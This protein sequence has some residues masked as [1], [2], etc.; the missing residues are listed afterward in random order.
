MDKDDKDKKENDQL[1]NEWREKMTKM[2]MK[3]KEKD[4]EINKIKLELQEERDYWA[5]FKPFL[6][7]FKVLSC[8]NLHETLISLKVDEVDDW[9]KPVE[10]ILHPE[11]IRAN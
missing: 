2:N 3:M 11:R 1:L 9:D 6:D 4:E 7:K 8:K 5:Q 10:D